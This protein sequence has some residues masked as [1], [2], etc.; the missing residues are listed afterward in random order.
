MRRLVSLLCAAGLAVAP[1]SAAADPSPN[2]A[3]SPPGPAPTVETFEWSTVTSRARLGVMVIGITSELRKHFGAAADRGVL[4][5]RVEPRSAAEAA[6]LR[7]GD[8]IVEVRGEGV[9][10]AGDV[11]SALATVKQ[12]DS[13][14][15]GVIRDRKPL[16]LTA[17]LTSPPTAGTDV[18]PP[19]WLDDWFQDMR[20]HFDRPDRS[21]RPDRPDRSTWLDELLRPWRGGGG[22][23]GG[24][25]TT[26]T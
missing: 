6:G 22:K 9:D 4:V 2:P 3:P 11:I 1:L 14:S 13:V 15:I 16:T 24:A 23:P 18:A 17:K 12:N 20:R 19:R 25:S 8:V 5:G 10:T 7:V 26:S 21:D